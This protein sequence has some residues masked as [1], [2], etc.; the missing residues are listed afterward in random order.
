MA[1]THFEPQHARKAFPCFDDPAM[2]AQ[3][4]ITV[5]R[6]SGDGYHALSNMNI[7]V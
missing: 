4:D 2:K 5:I 7:E 6:P 3:F 1:T